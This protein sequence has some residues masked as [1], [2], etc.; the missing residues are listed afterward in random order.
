MATQS[1]LDAA[2]KALHDLV[3]G[4]RVVSV[5][6]DGRKVEF[7]AINVSELKQ[8]I[9]ELELQIGT[10]RRCRPAGFHL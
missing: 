3:T 1:D 10:G 5:Q 2:R 9:T 8:Y 7:S 4:K 6:K